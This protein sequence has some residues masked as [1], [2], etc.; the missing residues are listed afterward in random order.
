MEDLLE[1]HSD[2]GEEF[3]RSLD[4]ITAAWRT[5]GNAAA[6]NFGR[7]GGGGEESRDGTEKRGVSKGTP[8]EDVLPGNLD[9][10]FLLLSKKNFPGI[11]VVQVFCNYALYFTC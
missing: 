8:M 3:R 10:E 1:G 6:S 7:E 2:E 11:S 9:H 5:G 4:H